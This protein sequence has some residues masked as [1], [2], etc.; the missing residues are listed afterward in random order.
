MGHRLTVELATRALTTAL[1]N[2]KPTAGLLH[3]SNCGIQYAACRY[4]WLLSEHGI[5]TS[6]SRT[7]NCRDNACVE[8]F[9]PHSRANVSLIVRTVHK[10]RRPKTSLST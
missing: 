9:S 10:T 6:V 2:R 1:T 4:Q 5:T 3:H 7:G 8:C